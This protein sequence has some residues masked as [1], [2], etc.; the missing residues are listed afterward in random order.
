MQLER[1]DAEAASAKAAAFRRAVLPA[2]WD[3][4]LLAHYDV[5][6]LVDTRE[7][8][9]HR[10]RATALRDR[11]L[12]QGVR[13]QTRPLPVGDFLAVAMPR[14][15]PAGG[16]GSRGGGAGGAG[17]AG[18]GAGGGTGGGAGGGG[19]GDTTDDEDSDELLVLDTIVERKQLC[20]FLSTVKN[21]RHY[22]SQKARL[23]RCGLGRVFFLVEGPL[24]R[25]PHAGEKQRMTQELSEIEMVDGLLLHMSRNTD[26]T[27]RF[28]SAAAD[29]L[30]RLLGSR[31]GRELR[32]AG[33]VRSWAEFK[34]DVSPPEV[35][36]S[37]FGRMLLNIHGLSA[38][39]VSNVLQ[40]HPTPRALA[41]AL[42][43]HARACSL[44]SL[45]ADHSGWLLAEVLVSGK[46]RRK[47]SENVTHFF[48][49]ADLPKDLPP[50]DSQ[51]Q[52]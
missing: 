22:H 23:A 16:V 49:L 33:L 44:R 31:T 9:S 40:R 7:K 6:I 48:T 52:V 11:L 41:E 42:D 37:A 30:R 27:V 20:D 28:L 32:D 10:E 51:S 5:A 43:S 17:G 45:P 21:K 14:G 38:P 39:M 12:R 8:I 25:W 26:E 50:P 18:G 4:P 29:R 35:V 1:A 2:S 13:S 24:E 15:Q 19:G 3:G 46:K 47:L 36:S 34:T